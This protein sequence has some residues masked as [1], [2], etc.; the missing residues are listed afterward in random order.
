MLQWRRFLFQ[1]NPLTVEEQAAFI[2]ANQLLADGK[3]SEAVRLIE[4]IAA[5]MQNNN[6]PR[7]A[8]NLYARAAHFCIEANNEQAA[9]GNARKSLILFT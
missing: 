8:A 3:P 7:Q 6:H 5:M 4:S 2:I 1:A 9:L